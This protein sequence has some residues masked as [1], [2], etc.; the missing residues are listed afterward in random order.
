MA[1]TPEVT[2]NEISALPVQ[3]IIDFLEVLGLPSDN[4]IAEAGQRVIMNK[5]LPDYILSLPDDVKRDARYLSKYVVGAG[6]G[7]FDYSLN[8][9]WNEVTIALRVKA[10]TYGLDIFFDAAIGAKL[11]EAYKNEDD[12]GGLKDIVLLDTCKKLELISETTYKKLAHILDMRNDIGISHPTNYTINA[13]ELLGWLQTCVE[14]VL[15]DQPSEAAIQVKAFIDNLKNEAKVLESSRIASVLPNIKKLSSLQCGRILTTLFGLYVSIDTSQ[16]LRKNIALI[17]PT[18]WAHSHDD[19]KFK[20]GIT[21]QGYN[22]NLHIAKHDKGNEFFDLVKGNNFRTTDAKII[23]LSELTDEL[24]SANSGRDNYYHE[25]PPMEKILTYINNA[26]DLPSEIAPDLIKTVLKCR[27]GRGL[28][29]KN[30]VS[31][32]GKPLYDK[33]FTIMRE[34]FVPTFLVQLFEYDVRAKI[35]NSISV[36][37]LIELLNVIKNNTVNDRYLEALNYLI[38]NF[39]SNY[40]AIKTKEFKKISSAFLDWPE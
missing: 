26:K 34:E 5:N 20:L 13:Y 31:S 9:V 19:A 36:S 3:K 38:A 7:L 24:A 17:A 14:D 27:I 39:P 1:D 10:I 18:L 21:L 29:Y 32:L 40:D 25:V 15:L 2:H 6:F 8:A 4:I 11:R 22:N 16:T 23:A 37:Q 30:G 28:P 35:R 12:L 33:F